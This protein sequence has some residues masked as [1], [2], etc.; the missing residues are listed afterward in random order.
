MIIYIFFKKAVNKP[1][2]ETGTQLLT[3][4]DIL[5]NILLPFCSVR[6]V[7]YFSEYK[8][9]VLINSKTASKCSTS[10]NITIQSKF[11]YFKDFFKLMYVYVYFHLYVSV[12]LLKETWVIMDASGIR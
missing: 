2:L 10:F 11:N 8:T 7:V 4:F 6:S 12:C 3:I 5:L 9:E 1:L